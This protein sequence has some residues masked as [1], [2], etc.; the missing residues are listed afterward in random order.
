MLSLLSTNIV[1]AESGSEFQP[2]YMRH[3]RTPDYFSE[4]KERGGEWA[5]YLGA[6]IMSKVS[7]RRFSTL[8]RPRH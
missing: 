1:D 7:A 5:T 8:G 2:R 6:C 3:A 4:F